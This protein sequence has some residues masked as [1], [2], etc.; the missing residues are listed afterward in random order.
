MFNVI[1]FSLRSGKLS[2]SFMHLDIKRSY[3][4]HEVPLWPVVQTVFCPVILG[5]VQSDAH[6]L[7]CRGCLRESFLP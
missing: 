3:I 6:H 7:R 1:S 5:H 2:L 4:C